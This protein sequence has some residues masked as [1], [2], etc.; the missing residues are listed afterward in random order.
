M[1][2]LLRMRDGSSLDLLGLG[3]LVVLLATIAVA[4]LLIAPLV[5]LYRNPPVRPTT[6]RDDKQSLDAYNAGI[7]Q[8][9]QM[10]DGRSMFFEPSPPNLEPPSEPSRA[11]GGPTLVAY[12]NG[13]AWFS[14]GQRVSAKEPDGRTVRFIR[15]DPPW[16]IRVAWERAEF[17]V[18]L[19]DKTDIATLKG[20]AASTFSSS[21]WGS[22]QFRNQPPPVPNPP[23]GTSS[24]TPPPEPP[25]ALS[26]RAPSDRPWIP[27]EA[28]IGPGPGPNDTPPAQSEQP[29]HPAD[30]GAPPAQ[31][32]APPSDP[33]KEP[34]PPAPPAPPSSP[35]SRRS[36]SPD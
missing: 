20:T 27:P 32:A 5:S 9:V 35:E 11:Y 3:A 19:F 25:G 14:D 31:G 8:H 10:V 4:A 22:S 2:R 23:A 17:D 29:P 12:I 30:P 33:A 26:G 13:T 18:K 34:A 36:T 24:L 16:S 7:E 15:A 21:P 6:L 1:N 28:R